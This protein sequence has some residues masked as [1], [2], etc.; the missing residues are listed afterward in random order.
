MAARPLTS[1]RIIGGHLNGRKLRLPPAAT[2]RPSGARLREALFN[3]LGADL[4]GFRCLDLFAGSGALGF[5]AASHQAS[6]ITLVEKNRRTAAMLKQLAA[7]LGANVSVLAMPASRLLASASPT[8]KFDLVFLDP[9]FADYQT[10]SAWATLLTA[11][12]PHV[13]NEA[14]L[15]CEHTR[16]F[17]PPPAWRRQTARRT[18]SVHW[19]LLRPPAR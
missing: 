2:L 19:Q 17:T 15:Y 1:V 3:H 7:Q 18:G 8:V 6:H 14:L 16:H 9:P 12:L 4:R 11:L 13:A 10:D 5:T